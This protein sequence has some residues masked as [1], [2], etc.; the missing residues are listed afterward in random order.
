MSTISMGLEALVVLE[1]V[2][3]GGRGL[4]RMTLCKGT[5][6]ASALALV[7]VYCPIWRARDMSTMPRFRGCGGLA[8][9]RAAGR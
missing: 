3:G 2:Q 8:G 5:M 4:T 6:V 9:V 7:V 1:E